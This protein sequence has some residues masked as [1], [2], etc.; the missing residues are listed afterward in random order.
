[1]TMSE[2][3]RRLSRFLFWLILGGGL[4]LPW[5]TGLWVKLDLQAQGAPTW[6]WAF[7]LN[8]AILGVEL[9]VTA[10][11]GLPFIGLAMMSR[12][13][14]EKPL[15]FFNLLPLERMICISISFL[16]GLYKGIL[17]YHR[18]FLKFHPIAFFYPWFI[19]HGGLEM[20]LG[21]LGVWIF[22]GGVKRWLFRTT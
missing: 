9:L 1:M 10:Y 22:L 20:L 11:W 4:L 6:P 21:L 17:L 12:Y 15:P 2:R 14:M 5:G 13:G 18:M 3:D 7:F 8:P 19:Y 16:V